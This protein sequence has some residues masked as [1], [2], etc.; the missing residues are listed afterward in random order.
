[1]AVSAAAEAL[2]GAPT[3]LV[4]VTPLI[5]MAEEE[6]VTQ[7]VVSPHHDSRAEEA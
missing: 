1:M 2:E 3:V 5:S 4:E 7:K 6:E